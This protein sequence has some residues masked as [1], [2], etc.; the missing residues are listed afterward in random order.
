MEVIFFAFLPILVQGRSSNIP[1]AS[2]AEDLFSTPS[3]NYFDDSA[4][5]SAFDSEDHTSNSNIFDPDSSLFASNYLQEYSPADQPLINTDEDSQTLLG[6]PVTDSDPFLDGFD[7]LVAMTEN[8]SEN[9]A[10]IPSTYCEDSALETGD[11]F[12]EYDPNEDYSISMF[13]PS[14]S[15]ANADDYVRM[16]NLKRS[17]ELRSRGGG[18]AG[19]HRPDARPYVTVTRYD[20]D[21]NTSP[22]TLNINA[23]AADG[24]PISPMLCPHGTKRNC[25]IWDALPPFSQCWPWARY[26]TTQVCRLAKN[27][28]CCDE[29][30]K[31]GGEGINCQDMKWTRSRDARKQRQPAEDPPPTSSS[32]L[33]EIFP[34]LQ[35]LPDLSP[36]P[37]LDF[38]SPRRW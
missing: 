38:C 35:P 4:L 31:R 17:K 16:F 37:S 18:G 8:G 33:Q 14:T 22:N 1:R 26:M 7:P 23:Y 34:I 24:T 19:G 27:Q 15:T 20:L 13:D 21:P 11:F 28:F 10:S 30:P 32:E 5:T 2:S 3:F 6:N 9:G 12:A 29:V 25:C 36:N